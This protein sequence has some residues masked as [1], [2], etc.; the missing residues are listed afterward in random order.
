MNTKI[1]GHLIKSL[2]SYNFDPEVEVKKEV[3]M[4]AG[5]RPIDTTDPTVMYATNTDVHSDPT[6]YVQVQ[7][8]RHTK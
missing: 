5:S 8:T 7:Y 1:N 6:R 2:C 4:V 3:N